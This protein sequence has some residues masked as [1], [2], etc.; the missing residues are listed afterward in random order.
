MPLRESRAVSCHSGRVSVVLCPGQGSQ[1]PGMLNDWIATG[2]ARDLA[3]RPMLE[4]WSSA[5][6]LDL[7]AHGCEADANTLRDTAVAQPLI[8]ATSLLSWRL[9]QQ[10]TGAHASLTA[11]HSV[12]ELAALAV[13]GVISDADAVTLAAIRGRAMAAAAAETSTS[14]AAVIGGERTEILATLEEAGLV[15]ANMNGSSQV[16]A[17]GPSAAITELIENPPAGTRVVQLAVAGAFH[18]DAMAG[19]VPV[20]AAAV[21][22]LTAADPTCPIVSNRD[23]AALMDGAQALERIPA[24]ITQPVRWDLCQDALASAVATTGVELAPSGVLRGLVRRDLPTLTIT[25]LTPAVLTSA[26]R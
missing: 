22:E 4:Q 16:V 23:G 12:G 13:A 3:P 18:T 25:A 6:D 15:P 8:V 1:R 26:G 5:A 19:A 21:Q 14:M 11:G 24:Q 20:V 7:I 17:A 9:Y 2:E 10:L